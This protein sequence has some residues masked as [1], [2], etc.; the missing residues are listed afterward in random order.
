M[1][2]KRSFLHR[3]IQESIR[4]ANESIRMANEALSEATT[5]LK[6]LEEL[7]DDE[8]N[9]VTGAG[10]PF[11]KYGSTVGTSFVTKEPLNTLKEVI[12]KEPM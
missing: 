10:D 7:T 8:L 5:A 4:M 2:L 1:R 3:R 9:Q 6:A 11:E 12:N